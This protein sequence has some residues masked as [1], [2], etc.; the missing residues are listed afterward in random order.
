[1]MQFEFLRVT[2]PL[3]SLTFGISFGV[4]L[5]LHAK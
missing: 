2:Q 4:L 5:S 1:M 3:L